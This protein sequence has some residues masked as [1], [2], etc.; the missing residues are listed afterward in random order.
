MDG[1]AN[2]SDG[3]VRKWRG[4]AGVDYKGLG[5]WGRV[6]EAERVVVMRKDVQGVRE[7]YRLVSIV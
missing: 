2:I 4:S 1:I 3:A 5:R 6:G 7:S